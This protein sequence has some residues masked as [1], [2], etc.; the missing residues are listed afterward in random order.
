[1]MLVHLRAS[2]SSPLRWGQ[3]HRRLRRPC[4]QEPEAEVAVDAPQSAHLMKPR[5]GLRSSVRS[6]IR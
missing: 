3:E 1:M 5:D 4:R 2:L 6:R